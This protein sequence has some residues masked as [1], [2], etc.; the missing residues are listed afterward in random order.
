MKPERPRLVALVEYYLPGFRAG[1]PMRSISAL[2]EQL[3]DEIDFYVITRD[4]D[5]GSGDP[6]PDCRHGEWK[7]LGKAKVRYLAPG[8][9]T[10][11]RLAAAVGEVQPHAVYLNSFFAPMSLR[12]LLA[13]RFGAL[14]GVP[15]VL[16]PRGELSPGA[17]R[18]KTLKKRSFLRLST[19][20]GL[21][22]DVV[23]HASTD[24]EHG[25]ISGAIRLTEAP[26]IARNPIAFDR[27]T[28]GSRPKASGAARF[29]FLSRITR[30]KNLLVAIELL[31]SVEG[32]VEL[33][34]YGPV[35]DAAYWREC[36]A[37]VGKMPPNVIVMYRGPIAHDRVP[38]ALGANHFFLLPT[39]SENFGHA[40]VEALLAGCPLVISDQTPWLGLSQRG[41]GWDLP[42]HDARTWRDALQTCLDMDAAS[43]EQASLRAAAL[44]GQIAAADTAEEHRRLFRSI[45]DPVIAGKIA[46]ESGSPGVVSVGS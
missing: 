36:L 45:F 22:A 5:E 10:P 11:G 34:I 44:G 9:L 37:L 2:V 31:R 1:G 6:Y 16:A 43:Y 19:W 46:R 21:Y 8:E 41:V 27:A 38:A 20:A 4:R 18:L 24:R 39:A 32:L 14:K 35:I 40:I 17:L 26:R 12:L 33:E 42:L 13:R 3:G 15:I 30:K 28:M 25:E 23:F 29:V 7:S